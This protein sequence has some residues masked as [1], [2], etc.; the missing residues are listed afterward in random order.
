MD[1]DDYITSDMY[2]YMMS[3][4]LKYNADI[5]IFDDAL[6]I[7]K[8]IPLYKDVAA[9]F[10]NKDRLKKGIYPCMLFSDTKNEPAI[11]PSLCNK[12]IRKTI[13]DNVLSTS[14]ENIYYGEDAICTYPC[15]LDAESVYIAK[16]KFFYIYRQTGY[17]LSKLK[18]YLS[19]PRFKEVFQA[20]KISNLDKRLKFK[21]HL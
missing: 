5:G 18:K 14:N 20:V 8:R 15:M 12:I 7:K 17:S 10:Y 21:V 4:I 2:E 13:L 3:K 1:S 9:C 16:D 19:D 6:E 11:A